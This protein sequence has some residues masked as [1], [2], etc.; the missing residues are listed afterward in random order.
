MKI[1]HLA[2]HSQLLPQVKDIA[3]QLLTENEPQHWAT[4]SS[5]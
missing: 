4:L 1:T 2:H 5:R 3:G